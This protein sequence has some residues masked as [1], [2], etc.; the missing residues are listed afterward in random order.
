MRRPPSTLLATLLLAACTTAPPGPPPA[1]WIGHSEA[2]L[3][4]AL[5][6]PTRFY[7]AP[8]GRR[9]LAYDST[10]SAPVVVPSFGLGFGGGSGGWG[11]WSGV[12][13]GIGLSFGSGA[14][15]CTTTYEVQ[16]GRVVTAGSVGPGCR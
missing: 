11:S 15:P 2:E 12:G 4:A 16:A 6:V 10:G 9:F 7:D 13:T 14:A 5:G 1:A 8:G 3:V